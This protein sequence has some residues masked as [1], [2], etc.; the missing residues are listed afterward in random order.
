[1]IFFVYRKNDELILFLTTL[2]GFK[3]LQINNEFYIF[4]ILENEVGSAEDDLHH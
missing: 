1:M 3:T 4:R 2:I